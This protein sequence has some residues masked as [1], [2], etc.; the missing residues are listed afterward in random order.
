M[1]GMST[2]HR[3]WAVGQLWA[4][5][6]LCHDLHLRRRHGPDQARQTARDHALVILVTVTPIMRIYIPNIFFIT[7]FFFRGCS[8]L[9]NS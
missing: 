4:G 3:G 9:M 5:P 8:Y 6:Q 1:K 7:Q 2:Q